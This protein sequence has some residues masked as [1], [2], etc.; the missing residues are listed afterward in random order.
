MSI[1][2]LQS[3][4]QPN[5][6]STMDSV[7]EEPF[8]AGI[9]NNN[10]ND[11]G[12]TAS[13]I[14]PEL[15]Q[16]ADNARATRIYGT[17][18]FV[19]AIDVDT[20]FGGFKAITFQDLI[21]K[22][23]IIALCHGPIVSAELLYTRMHSS[24]VTSETMRSLD[25]DCVSQLNGALK[26]ISEETGILFYLIQEGRGCGYVGKS[27]ACMNVQWHEN[28][29]NEINTFEAYESLGMIHDYRDY[30]N[31]K[32]IVHLMGLESDKPF[33]LLTNNPDKISKFKTL[34]LN[35]ERVDAIEIPPNPF[36]QQYLSSKEM[37]GHILYQTKEKVS[38][39]TL[40]HKRVKPFQPYALDHAKRFIHVS[41][42]YLPIRPTWNQILL[43]ETEFEELKEKYP[44]ETFQFQLIG[45]HEA[46]AT[47]SSSSSS[48]GEGESTEEKDET[49]VP[50]FY[51]RIPNDILEKEVELLARPYWFKVN[52]FY[53]IVTHNDYLV[54]E[55][56]DIENV[57]PI[58]RIH[59][60][61]IFDR[62]PLKDRMY[63]NRYKRSLEYIVR[64]GSG[65][66][67]LLYRDGRGAGLGY[68]VLNK[69][70]DN[71]SSKDLGV[72]VD[73]DAR[74]YHGSLTLL[75]HFLPK[76]RNLPVSVMHGESS[77]EVLRE[78]FT[79]HGYEVLRWIN[80]NK[81]T[82]LFGYDSIHHRIVSVLR[83]MNN[84]KFIGTLNKLAE[85]Q[86]FAD[87]S[88]RYLVTGIGS[89]EAHAK[90]TAVQLR[91]RVWGSTGPRPN[92][93]FCPLSSVAKMDIQ[94]NDRLI[95]FTQGLSPNTIP[96][97]AA[98]NYQNVCLI[99]TADETS[100]STR[101]EAYVKILGDASNC[102][103]SYA[104]EYMDNTLIRV[105]GPFLGF[106]I[107]EQIVR[108]I[109]NDTLLTADHIGQLDALL[110]K[111]MLDKEFRHIPNSAIQH[112]AASSDCFLVSE[113]PVS[114]TI[115]NIENKFSE[116]L[117]LSTSSCEYASFAHG[118]YQ[119]IESQRQNNRLNY[120][121]LIKTTNS[122]MVDK[123]AELIGGGEDGN[124]RYLII[125]TSK[126]VDDCELPCIDL[127]Q[128]LSLEM[129]VND[130]V[131]Q[132][133]QIKGVN[134]RTWPGK[135]RQSVL[136]DVTT[137]NQK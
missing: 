117:F 125:D 84:D 51:V 16:L 88:A 37:Y 130:L 82:D 17:T 116:G 69:M 50:R 104:K 129:F 14:D 58:I 42:Y 45:Q 136:Y 1:N 134:Q 24:C 91:E 78:N 33:S 47:S 20:V 39:Y 41:S 137:I 34:G 9:I 103:I 100:A 25:C 113:S 18:V 101:A 61:S 96:A 54:L 89:S 70:Q 73:Q 132:A 111:V 119:I 56:G 92:F 102:V 107:A 118:T 4:I 120:V 110:Q 94:P 68:Y 74:D 106:V 127:V 28:T 26:K 27:R 133:M 44:D 131:F 108:L 8:E 48:T 49:D 10:N 53:D 46:A 36:N 32:D 3:P 123:T 35:L 72:W 126:L 128:M 40:P 31:V 109:S 86:F 93:D 122:F 30:R 66:I 38:K 121:V 135:E 5:N 71:T 59:S 105:T 81:Q 2:D 124:D 83:D 6:L 60:E 85:T 98:F 22:N 23:Y 97:M 19:G 29:E 13:P 77:L 21:Q 43:T 112:I 12:D 87:N 75:R 79:S 67:V 63:K 80:L 95:L 15:D 114:E 65:L 99:T 11:D 76:D 7:S 115:V 64:N 55:Y 90:Y 57:P 52:V 62:F